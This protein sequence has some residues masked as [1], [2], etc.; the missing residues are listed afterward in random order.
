MAFGGGSVRAMSN[1]ADAAAGVAG[2]VSAD[3][4]PVLVIHGIGTRDK[5]TYLADV[6]GLN[7]AL[8]QDVRL[9]P[10]WWG[11][12][13]AATQPLDTILPYLS[14]SSKE[15]RLARESSAEV[16]GAVANRDLGGLMDSVSAGWRRR[17]GDSR[18]RILGSIYGLVRT[19]YQRASGEFTGDLILYQRHQAALHARIWE[20]VMQH[21]PGYGLAEQPIDVISHSLGGAMVFDLA[22]AG[23]PTL[24]VGEFLTCASQISYFHVI[25]CSPASIDP[26]GSGAP[27]TLPATIR[28]WTNFFVPLDPWAFLAAPLFTMA[29]GAVPDDV[30]VYA[31][32]RGDRVLTHAA[33]YYWTHPVFMAS[34]RDRLGLTAD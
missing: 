8:G 14:W 10:V 2:Q 7:R 21:A 4:R 34:V 23:F 31:G 17:S 3:Q 28:R 32:E 20:T 9:I 24:H 16:R 15:A 19:Q 6:A 18:R 12:M 13:G 29:D 25:G 5:G 27:V 26:T 11:D 1:P 33:S 30:E 22:V